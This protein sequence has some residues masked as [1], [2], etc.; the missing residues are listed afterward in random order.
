VTTKTQVSIAIPIGTAILDQLVAI[1]ARSLSRATAH[2]LLAIRFNAKQRARA[3]ALSAKARES[4]LD[5]AGEKE[6]DDYLHV[7][8]LLAVLHSKARQALRNAEHGQ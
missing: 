7:A 5:D 1:E 2:E 4:R 6:L 8:D 3:K